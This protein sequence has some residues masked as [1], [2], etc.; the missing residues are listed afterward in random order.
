ML[1]SLD[2]A[3]SFVDMSTPVWKLVG[4]LTSLL[5]SHMSKRLR[6]CNSNFEGPLSRIQLVWD[7]GVECYGTSIIACG[8][9]SVIHSKIS[10]TTADVTWIAS[11]SCVWKS[12]PLPALSSILVSPIPVGKRYIW[13]RGCRRCSISRIILPRELCWDT[14]HDRW[15]FFFAQAIWKC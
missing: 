5:P 4:G 3:I 11:H 14:P 13:F 8:M 2:T 10:W 7:S 1:R 6:I 15:W 9:S 12:L